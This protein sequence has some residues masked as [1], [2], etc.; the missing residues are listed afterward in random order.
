M[1][2]QFGL[3]HHNLRKNLLR[4]IRGVAGGQGP[5]AKSFPVQS[6]EHLL[7]VCRYVERNAAAH[8]LDGPGRGLAMG[9]TVAK[10]VR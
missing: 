6:D 2:V 10:S 1:T 3:R 7:T 8:R 9:E 4:E 5:L